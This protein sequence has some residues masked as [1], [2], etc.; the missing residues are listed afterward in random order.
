MN[1]FLDIFLHQVAS[2]DVIWLTDW[3]DHKKI[4]FHFILYVQCFQFQ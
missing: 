1:I 2:N 4:Q 3:N